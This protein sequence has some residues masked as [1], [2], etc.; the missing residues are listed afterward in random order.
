MTPEMK[1]LVVTLKLAGHDV[2]GGTVTVSCLRCWAA[3]G[4]GNRLADIR[5]CEPVLGSISAGHIQNG[6]ITADK[7]I[8]Y[9]LKL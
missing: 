6:T 1:A 4:T 3:W 7:I 2:N 8:A 9:K 5:Q